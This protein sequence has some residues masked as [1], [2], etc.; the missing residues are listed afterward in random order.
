MGKRI[1][2]IGVIVFFKGGV[3]RMGVFGG[4]RITRVGRRVVEIIVF[5]LGAVDHALPP[6]HILFTLNVI[7]SGVA[8]ILP[9]RSIV[10]MRRVWAPS[11]SEL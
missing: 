6:P 8:S 7:M 1:V 11:A 5:G 4:S 3:V 2:D 9:T 10:R